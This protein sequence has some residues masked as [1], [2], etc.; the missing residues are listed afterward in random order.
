[1]NSDSGKS[2]LLC[3]DDKPFIGYSSF[4]FNIFSSNVT[5]DS[6]SNSH[7]VDNDNNNNNGNNS[8]K[9]K[10]F[11]DHRY[12]RNVK[13]KVFSDANMVLLSFL[14]GSSFLI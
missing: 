6:N 3:F 11:F 14:G 1:M 10:I 8:I 13:R 9:K 2:P 4:F 7:N 12:S 5:E